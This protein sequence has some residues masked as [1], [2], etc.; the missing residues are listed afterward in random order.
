MRIIYIM[1]K[2]I[3]GPIAT[4]IPTERS[5]E[6]GPFSA[7]SQFRGYDIETQLKD[8]NPRAMDRI[9]NCCIS[10]RGIGRPG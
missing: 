2:Y 5:T 8:T 3:G 10:V 1:L 9:L 7:Q 4:R 6:S